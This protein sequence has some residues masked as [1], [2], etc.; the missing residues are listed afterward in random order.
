M[1]HSSMIASLFKNRKWINRCALVAICLK[2]NFQITMFQ[3]MAQ[4][5]FWARVPPQ[6]QNIFKVT[7]FLI[8]TSAHWIAFQISTQVKKNYLPLFHKICGVHYLKVTWYLVRHCFKNFRVAYS[9]KMD[10]SKKFI[11]YHMPWLYTYIMQAVQSSLFR[12]TLKIWIFLPF[13]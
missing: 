3:R 8:S 11:Q 13:L 6:Q 1:H 12:I 2:E 9:L 4:M 10:L 7:C 5:T